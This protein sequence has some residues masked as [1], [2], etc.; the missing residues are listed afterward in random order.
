[1]YR[2]MSDLDA[3]LLCYYLLRHYYRTSFSGTAIY[4]FITYMLC[5]TYTCFWIISYKF[6]QEIQVNY[7]YK[8]T[9]KLKYLYIKT[10]AGQ[11]RGYLCISYLQLFIIMT[12]TLG[13]GSSRLL[14]AVNVN[15][16]SGVSHPRLDMFLCIN[17]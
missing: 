13:F 11:G 14:Y 16:L 8:N 7:K 10:E 9:I 12:L 6:S 15:T 3:E 1:M 5:I 2:N 4:V 17:L